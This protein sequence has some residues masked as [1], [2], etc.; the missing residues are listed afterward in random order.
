M[1]VYYVE[2][3]FSCIDSCH[4][5]LQAYRYL[6]EE[7]KTFQGK[8]IMVSVTCAAISSVRSAVI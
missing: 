6:R 3:L 7:V 1:L 5:V 4:I 2:T 8:P